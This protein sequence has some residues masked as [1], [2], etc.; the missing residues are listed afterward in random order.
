[1][2]KKKQMHILQYV[3]MS[4]EFC[5]VQFASDSYFFISF[6]PSYNQSVIFNGTDIFLFL[7]KKSHYV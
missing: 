1:M 7:Y 4:R 6:I 3:V 2:I 5:E